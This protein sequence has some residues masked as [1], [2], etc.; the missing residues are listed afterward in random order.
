MSIGTFLRGVG[1][2]FGVVVLYCGYLLVTM[3]QPVPVP[4]YTVR[5]NR[6]TRVAQVQDGDRWTNFRPDPYGASLTTDD[7]SRLR[8]TDITWGPR[9]I[10]CARA[11]NI[12]D[13]PVTGRLSFRVVLR[14][15]A[16][17]KFQRDRSLRESVDFPPRRIVPFVLRTDLRTP[18]T[19]KTRTT[20]QL[21]PTA[22]TGN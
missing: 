7:F 4:G 14:D 15:S 20:I 18:D 19:Q 22:T 3:W 9:G 6:F 11:E 8:I 5:Q 17:E 21:E 1:L 13:Q 10:L 2:V 16:D 12:S